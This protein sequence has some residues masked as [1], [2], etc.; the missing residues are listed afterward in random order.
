MINVGGMRIGGMSGIYKSHDYEKGHFEVSPYGEREKK[1]CYHIRKYD[2]YKMLQVKE[3]MDVFLSHDWPLGIEQYG[4][5]KG[6]IHK[7]KF[8]AKEVPITS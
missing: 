8:F 2:V 1:S 5:T 7:K 4:D 3:P 6:L